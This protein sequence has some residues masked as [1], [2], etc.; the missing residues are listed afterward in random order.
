MLRNKASLRPRREALT[1]S[2]VAI[3]SGLLSLAAAQAIANNKVDPEL[4]QYT[5]VRGVAGSMSSTGSDSLANL[6]SLWAEQFMRFYPG[7]TIQVKAAGSS[8]APPALAE[9]MVSFGPMSRKMEENERLAFEQN[10][11]YPATAVVVAIDALAV[12]VHKDNPIDSLSLRQLDAIF[13]SNRSCSGGAGKVIESWGQLGLPNSWQR[14][15]I[16]MFG[17]NSASGTYGYFKTRVLC[18]GDF[19]TTVNEQPGSA[20]VVQAV[21]TTINAIGYSGMGY[22][23]ASVRPVAVGD[24]GNYFEASAENA[25][26]GVYP[27]SRYLYIYLNKPP[28]K[29]LPAVERE[30][31]RFVLSRQGQKVVLK[32]GYIS[33]PAAMAQKQRSIL[34]L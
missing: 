25:V 8:T 32:D 7:V 16:Q 34:G 4:S 1:H 15:D 30:F 13:S 28:D 6:M 20:S 23:T 12:Y 3:F 26:A 2:L 14:R 17:R 10:F 31:I 29:P 9:G 19:G 27:L 5:K 24:N 11:G 18:G 33:L 22:R 21:G